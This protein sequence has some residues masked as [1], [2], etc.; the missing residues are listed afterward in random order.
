M[1]TLKKAIKKDTLKKGIDVATAQTLLMG[2]YTVL[3]VFFNGKVSA[4]ICGRDGSCCET[5]V[6]GVTG[7]LFPITLSYWFPVIYYPVWFKE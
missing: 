7:R 6:W 5:V 1:E 3:L 4:C 2:F